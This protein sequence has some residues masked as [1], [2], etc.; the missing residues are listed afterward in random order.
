MSYHKRLLTGG[1]NQCSR[2]VNRDFCNVVLKPLVNLL[3][4]FPHES[5]CWDLKTD[6]RVVCGEC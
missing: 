2:V 5:F 3:L 6:L 4:A 1:V